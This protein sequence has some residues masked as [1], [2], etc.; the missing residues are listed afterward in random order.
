MRG[1][2]TESLVIVVV[3]KMEP[4]DRYTATDAIE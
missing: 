2:N 4:K 1:N 3:G